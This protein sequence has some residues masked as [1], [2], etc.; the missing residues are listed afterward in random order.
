MFQELLREAALSAGVVHGLRLD[1]TDV[2]TCCRLQQLLC[3]KESELR[4]KSFNEI[5]ALM[6]QSRFY[7]LSLAVILSIN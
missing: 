6:N 2:A 3:D 7:Q 1:G 5:K 4:S